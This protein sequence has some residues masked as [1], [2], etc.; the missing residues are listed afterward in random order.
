MPLGICKNAITK[1]MTEAFIAAY[2]GGKFKG[3]RC[4]VDYAMGYPLNPKALLGQRVAKEFDGY[5][6]YHG[7]IVSH[8]KWWKVK[9]DDGE[10]EDMSYKDPSKL[11]QPPNFE[12]LRYKTPPAAVEEFLKRS[13]GSP[14]MTVPGVNNSVNT[15]R[16]EQQD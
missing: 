1:A 3:W 8:Q 7:T 6:L 4:S 12:V 5:G 10:Q 13:N 2:S 15:F 11:A 9:Y 16:L 14:T